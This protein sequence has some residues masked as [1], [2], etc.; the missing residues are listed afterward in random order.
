MRKIYVYVR[1]AAILLSV[2]TICTARAFGQ[3]QA[4]MILYHGKVATMMKDGEFVE[5]RLL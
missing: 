1:S 4:D 2:I 5:R 3:Q